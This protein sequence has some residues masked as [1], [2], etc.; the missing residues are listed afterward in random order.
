[1]KKIAVFFALLVMTG[2]CAGCSAAND[3]MN[4]VQAQGRDYGQTI[5]LEAGDT[6]S[7]AFFDMT[8][9]SATYASE[10]DGYV[11]SSDTDIFLV[12]NITVKNTF[13]S[14]DPIPMSDADFELS[15]KCHG[16]FDLCG[17][18]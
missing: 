6:M 14:S 7:T 3:A 9:N 11:P 17:A 8:V 1:M 13:D 16:K 5:E 10:I 15:Y 12:V 2:V 4:A 18:Q